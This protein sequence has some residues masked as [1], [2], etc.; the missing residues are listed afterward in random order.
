M[1][2]TDSQFGRRI[3]PSALGALVATAVALFNCLSTVVVFSSIVVVSLLL[4]CSWSLLCCIWGCWCWIGSKQI[5]LYL[6]FGT[7][8]PDLAVPWQ[9]CWLFLR[10]ALISVSV[11]ISVL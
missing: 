11:G 3:L 7:F 1:L 6:A 9:M 5:S 10:C 4:C 2:N 8:A